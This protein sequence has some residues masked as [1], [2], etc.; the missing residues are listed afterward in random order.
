MGKSL[1]MGG[2]E[3]HVN[4]SARKR[5]PRVTWPTQEEL[6]DYLGETGRK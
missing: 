3:K 6:A 4:E 5:A 1:R 2:R